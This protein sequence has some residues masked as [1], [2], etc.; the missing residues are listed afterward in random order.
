MCG[1]VAHKSMKPQVKL[2]E[3]GFALGDGPFTYEFPYVVCEDVK[4][5]AEKGGRGSKKENILV[6]EFKRSP[7]STTAIAGVCVTSP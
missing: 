1:T 6:R 2:Y 7:G 5:I 4:R 3:V